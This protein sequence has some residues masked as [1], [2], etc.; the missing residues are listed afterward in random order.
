M[1]GFVAAAAGCVTD[2]VLNNA[3]TNIIFWSAMSHPW[4]DCAP[5]SAQSTGAT[6][7]VAL[8]VMKN[9]ATL[10]FNIINVNSGRPSGLYRS[11]IGGIYHAGEEDLPG[12]LQ[13]AS[14]VVDIRQPLNPRFVVPSSTRR[15]HWIHDPHKYNSMKD[16]SVY[17]AVVCLSRPQ[18]HLWRAYFR[19]THFV[20]IPNL[21]NL[22]NIG[23][24]NM[25]FDRFQIVSTTSKVNMN[26][27]QQIVNGLR[28]VDPRFHAVVVAPS[29]KHHNIQG[30]HE[31]IEFL[32]AVG[33][34]DVLAL[35]RNSLANVYPK[36]FQENYPATYVE[37]NSLGTPMLT[38][39]VRGS[40]EEELLTEEQILPELAAPEDY[41]SRLVDWA[42]D[43]QRP[44]VDG[45][46]YESNQDIK[47]K[48][49]RVLRV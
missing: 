26:T 38:N 2:V 6:Q 17:D 47:L 14:H 34:A 20:R 19:G 4:D 30:A 35:V 44:W 29:Y 22:E 1:I 46:R 12:L 5:S 27:F 7:S 9:L 23:P 18:C 37:A 33:H 16:F 28:L 8:G 10:N 49:R 15:I 39:S 31:G 13:N 40:P 32:G 11:V 48:W 45:S 43:K 25:T 42:T 41:V 36:T 3:Q 21:V 24:P